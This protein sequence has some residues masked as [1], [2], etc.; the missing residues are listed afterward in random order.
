MA[1]PTSLQPDPSMIGGVSKAPSVRLPDPASIFTRRAARFRTLART[2]PLSA[3]LEF[4][5][6]IAAAQAA[7]LPALPTFSP[8]DPAQMVRAAELAMPPL[9]RGAFKADAVLYETWERVLGSLAGAEK[10]EAAE[11][12]LTRVRGADQSG[13]D[14]MISSILSDL[15]P[16]DAVA[17]H[18]FV[19][20][21][22]QV[23]FAR[24]AARLSAAALV[25]VGVGTCP[26][27]GGPPVTSLI[28]GWPGAETVRYASC[29]LCSTLW[30]EVRIKCLA[31]GATKGIGYQ[32]IAGQG[33][34]IKAETCDECGSYVK[35]LHQHRDVALDPVA[36][37]V[38]S[39]GLDQLL[40]GG[41]YRRAGVN[42]YLI[43]Y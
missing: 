30:N 29:A 8:P 12:A 18:V 22:L 31:C 4:L 23:H 35:I 2:S 17:E 1:D 37:D 36:D 34:T 14:A 38:G 10:P 25:P 15:I 7:A 26:A 5:A 6:D 40:A 32:E 13:R 41:R 28:V 24:R 19:A 11:A 33:E 20:A 39:L 27:C 9:D 16:P 42:P 21:V 3:Y 43:G